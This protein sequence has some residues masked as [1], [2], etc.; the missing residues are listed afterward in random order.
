MSVDWG[1]ILLPAITGAFLGARVSFNLDIVED[2]KHQRKIW[3]EQLKWHCPH[4]VM[5]NGEREFL[6]RKENG[7]KVCGYCDATFKKSDSLL[8]TPE[9]YKGRL[10]QIRKL[11]KKLGRPANIF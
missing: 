6:Y 8:I 11:R 3:K 1:H 2:H 10:N 5:V 7:L 4:F 9:M